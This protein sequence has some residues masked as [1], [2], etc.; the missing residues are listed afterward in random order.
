MKHSYKPLIVASLLAMVGLAAGAQTTPADPPMGMH[1]HHFDPA[2]MQERMARRQAALKQ[3]L[4]ITPA[5]EGAWNAWIAALKPGNFTR[6]DRAEWDKLTTPERIDR[7][8]ALRAQRLAEMDR[9]G[10]ATKAFYA[11]LSPEQKAIFD[12]QMARRHHR[13]RDHRG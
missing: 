13:W 12:D 5:Q 3:K 11:T 8:R 1:G 9:R 10:D 4:Q 6:P 2:K 7:M